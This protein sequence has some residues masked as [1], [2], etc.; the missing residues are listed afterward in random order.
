LALALQMQSKIAGLVLLSGYYFPTLRMEVPLFAIPAI[1][2]VGDLLR[3][4]VSPILGRLMTPWIVRQC[5][6]PSPV[7]S[8]FSR[9]PVPMAL[10]PSQIRATAAD[11]ALM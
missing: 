5:F 7:P 9:F 8:S 4:T 1:P 10:R 2:V 3:Y 6:A 11:T